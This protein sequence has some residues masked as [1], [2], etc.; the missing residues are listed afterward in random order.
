MLCPRE[1]TACLVKSLFDRLQLCLKLLILDRKPS[2]GILQQR[3]QV[4]YPL[5]AGK[6]FALSNTSLLLE[7]GV[8][9]DELARE[10]TS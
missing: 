9:V 2:V 7:G 3:L 10:D 8:L 4:L 6:E 1:L 5:I